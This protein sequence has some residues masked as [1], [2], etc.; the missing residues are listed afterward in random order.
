MK[1]I[2]KRHK[3]TAVLEIS[4][5]IS[6]TGN[7]GGSSGAV[8]GKI[9]EVD[10]D[11]AL[12]SSMHLADAATGAPMHSWATAEHLTGSADIR[13]LANHLRITVDQAVAYRSAWIE[14]RHAQGMIAAE[15][16]TIYLHAARTL[17][18]I[19]LSIERSWVHDLE[20][21]LGSLDGIPEKRTEGWV[22]DAECDDQQNALGEYLDC[23]ADDVSCEFDNT[24]LAEGM[25]YL[26]LTD[27]EADQQA[28]NYI[29]GSLWAFNA[30]FLE[31]FMPLNGENI[32]KLQGGCEDVNQAFRQL[33]GDKFDDFVET[34]I[35]ADGRGH[36]MSSYDGE[37]NFQSGFY[38]YRVN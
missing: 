14:Y 19:M 4:N 34:T 10:S 27:G 6:F 33:I 29:A 26:V 13:I 25:E 1:K 8:G 21:L 35:L 7:I 23:P 3:F 22:H 38:L 15:D 28:K 12:M 16:Q 24:Y 31:R 18:H 9:A 37:E 17:A 5:Y 36:F 32:K 20:N 2:F 30:D 11:F